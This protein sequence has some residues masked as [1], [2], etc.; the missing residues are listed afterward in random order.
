MSEYEAWIDAVHDRQDRAWKM[1]PFSREEL[2]LMHRCNALL[3]LRRNPQDQHAKDL[4]WC[5][6]D[7][8]KLETEREEI[9]AELVRVRAAVRATPPA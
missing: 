8:Q 2:L 9:L 1:R 4:L 7:I 6:D 3:A 5:L